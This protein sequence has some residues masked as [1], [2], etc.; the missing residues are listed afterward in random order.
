MTEEDLRR[1]CLCVR[2]FVCVLAHVQASMHVCLSL[3]LPRPSTTY[4]SCSGDQSNQ[5][6]S[7]GVLTSLVLRSDHMERCHLE[8]ADSAQVKPYPYCCRLGSNRAGRR[9]SRAETVI[10]VFLYEG[11]RCPNCRKT[12]Q[13]NLWLRPHT[14]DVNDILC[15]SR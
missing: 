1:E 6:F 8:G 15:A 3:S 9:K 14:P 5:S 2:V 13:R 12:V 11:S 4:D 7:L 10:V